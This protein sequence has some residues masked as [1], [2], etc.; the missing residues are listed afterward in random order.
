MQGQTDQR[1]KGRGLRLA[2]SDAHERL[3]RAPGHPQEHGDI[4][5]QS[6]PEVVTTR[7]ECD[8]AREVGF[9]IETVSIVRSIEVFDGFEYGG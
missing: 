6:W 2:P 7:F 5:G 3:V 9:V 1:L 4:R 8:A